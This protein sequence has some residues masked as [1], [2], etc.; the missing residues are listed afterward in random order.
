[1]RGKNGRFIKSI[2]NPSIEINFPT[3]QSLLK[4]FILL[5][6]F[7]PWIYLSFFKFDLTSIL[8]NA[9]GKLFGPNDCSC[10]SPKNEY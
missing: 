5:I 1:M 9:F 3:P 2:K 8:E 10:P 4:Y 6:I 7:L